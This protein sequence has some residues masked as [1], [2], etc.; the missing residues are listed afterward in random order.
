MRYIALLD[1]NRPIENPLMVVRVDDGREEAYVPGC[2]WEQCDPLCRTW[3]INVAI[4][5]E[6]ALALLPNLEPT[7]PLED[8]DPER[9]ELRMYAHEG[10]HEDTYYYAIET[11]EYPFDN[12]LTVL[13]RHWLTDREMHYTTELRW[14]R[15]SVEG[16]RARISTA[17]ADKV[18]DI[19]AMRVSGDATHRYYVITN[20]F[21]PDVDNPALIARERIGWGSEYHEHY[22]GG[23]IGSNAIYSVG[24][25]FVNGELTPV[26]AE[27]AARLVQS[28]T[29]RPEGTRVRYFACFD[30][31]DA[32][33]LLVRVREESGGLRVAEYRPEDG[34]W[35]LGDMG[36]YRRDYDLVEISEEAGAG[37]AS[38]LRRYQRGQA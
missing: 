6:Q 31:R 4:T 10:Y 35:Y 7:G 15:G 20:P 33:R 13:R 32:P 18:K 8:R 11:D 19:V 25:G 12:P 34:G 9:S 2:G 36:S 16:R 22:N 3:F 1:S 24:N 28:W 23:W 26:K 17:D 14:E 37:W 29:P 5:E 21:E 38:G 27:R 30:G